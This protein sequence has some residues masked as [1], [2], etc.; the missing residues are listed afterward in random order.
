[1][2]E[3]AFHVQRQSRRDE[4]MATPGEVDDEI[5]A[6][7]QVGRR[8]QVGIGIHCAATRLAVEH[9]AFPRAVEEIVTGKH[10][11]PDDDRAGA[12]N[13]RHGVHFEGDFRAA[14]E[15]Q[16]VGVAAADHATQAHILHQE[17][18]G[19][20]V[21]HANAV[22]VG[23]EQ[24]AGKVLRRPLAEGKVLAVAEFIRSQQRHRRRTVGYRHLL[25]GCRIGR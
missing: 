6:A 3:I 13:D 8:M 25:D 11:G 1:M 18:H 16:P 10:I 21:P 22:V 12:F 7:H 17:I 15:Q 19:D 23:R 20:L 24:D 9:Q 5:E 2:V 14:A 4:V